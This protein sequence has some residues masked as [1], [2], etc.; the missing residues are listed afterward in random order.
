VKNGFTYEGNNK[1]NF[2]PEIGAIPKDRRLK[3]IWL[4]DIDCWQLSCILFL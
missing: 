4:Q 3:K 2:F 1:L